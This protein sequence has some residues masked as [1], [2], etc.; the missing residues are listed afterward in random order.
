MKKSKWLPCSNAFIIVSTFL[1]S[2]DNLNIP[3]TSKAIIKVC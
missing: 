1:I 3:S 2:P